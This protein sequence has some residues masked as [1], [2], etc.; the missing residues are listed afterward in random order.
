M[1]SSLK[2]G[3]VIKKPVENFFSAPIEIH[4]DK[5]ADIGSN[6][7]I[8]PDFSFLD[9]FNP[10]IAG[11]LFCAGFT[12][13][14]LSVVIAIVAILVGMLLP[15]LSKTKEKA[16]RTRCL[17]NLK[18]VG[19]ASHMYAVD[20]GKFFSPMWYNVSYNWLWDIL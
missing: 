10:R 7:D 1:S 8:A 3:T 5:R 15:A 12:L 4:D 16:K 20:H 13:I 9:S 11:R 14:D 2:T 18:Q 17:S 19:I 6:G